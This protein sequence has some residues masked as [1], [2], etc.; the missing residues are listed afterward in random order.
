M[1]FAC[2]YFF[3]IISNSDQIT[4]YIEKPKP[5]TK[6]IT[7]S[8]NKLHPSDDF[9]D[10]E[11]ELDA[12]PQATLTYSEHHPVLPYKMSIVPIRPI[13]SHGTAKKFSIEPVLQGGLKLDPAT[14]II[15]GTPTIMGMKNVYTMTAHLESGKVNC[16]LELEVG[17]PNPPLSE[18]L[19]DWQNRLWNWYQWGNAAGNYGDYYL[20]A[21]RGHSVT[22]LKFHP[23]VTKINPSFQKGKVIISN[24]SL[25]VHGIYSLVRY[26]LMR[27]QHQ[28]FKCFLQYRNNFHTWYPTVYDVH[29][30]DPKAADL[31]I[32]MFPYASM[33]LGKS[34]SE[35]DE[36]HKF[37]YTLAAFKPEVKE[38]LKTHGLLMPTLQMIFRRTRVGSDQ[39]YLSGKAHPSAFDDSDNTKEMVKMAQYLTLD[40]LP[41]I[42][43]LK[44]L[45][46]T[47]HNSQLGFHNDLQ[48]SEHL[49]TTPHA[50]A[51]IY[52]GYESEK[53]MIVDLS[54]SYDYNNL[55]LEPVLKILRGDP[56]K[57]N[58]EQNPDNPM[59]F[60]VTIPYHSTYFD[61]HQQRP[62]N[63]VVIGAFTHNGHYYSPPSFITSFS[64]NNETRHYSKGQLLSIQYEA[65]EVQPNLSS[66]KTWRTDTMIYDKNQV[67]LGWKRDIDGKTTTY[68]SEGLVVQ[69]R[70]PSGQALKAQLIPYHLSPDKKYLQPNPKR[71]LDFEYQYHELVVPKSGKLDLSTLFPNSC[72][73]LTSPQAGRLELIEG[74]LTYVQHQNR[75]DHFSLTFQ[76]PE[77]AFI[78]KV[79]CRTNT[80]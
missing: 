10:S 61:P 76:T 56:D 47:Y 62:S 3:Q 70:L 40:H 77:G 31:S 69:K 20:N 67:W 74:R 68:N 75:N 65:K 12:L 44:V 73:L 33:S 71:I 59:I 80:L 25:G 43:H 21:D 37:F 6:K 58:I 54:S 1:L 11:L 26:Q 7:L 53:V 38:A 48:N 55:K 64:L 27:H 18:R 19:H 52:R 15:T 42:T 9:D 34:H 50:V 28:A 8:Q 51:R 78:A 46:E 41:P 2:I 22:E 24:A 39:E 66:K 36:M 4:T 16:S 17:L 63:L 23:Q 32:A 72:H 79:H 35:Q 30:K 14:G 57:I 29:F 5:E 45:A 13:L 60:K 49:F